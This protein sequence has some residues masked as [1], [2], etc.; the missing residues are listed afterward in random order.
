MKWSIKSMV[1]NP[2]INGKTNVVVQA[3]WLAELEQNGCSAQTSGC[4]QFNLGESF[5][6]YENLIE[7]QVIGWVKES[8]GND[9]V[10]NIEAD[11]TQTISD[12]LNP[13]IAHQEKSLPWL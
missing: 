3:N 13:V 5:T 6:P 10:T 2:Q 4:Q 12:K 7:S 11:L 8:L 1:V 9:Q